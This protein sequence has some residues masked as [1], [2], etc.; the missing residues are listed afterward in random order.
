VPE[1]A[2]VVN[3]LFTCTANRVRSPFAAALA[4]QRVQARRLPVVVA[5]AGQLEPDRPAVD[6][7]V[8]VAQ[9]AAVDLTQ[10]RSTQLSA[11]LVEASD[12][13]VTMAGQ[14]VVDMVALTP[15]ARARTV[16]LRE[17]AAATESGRPLER[18]TPEAV[19]EW[20][21]LTTRRP[22]DLLLSGQLDV[23]DPIGRS[24]RHYRR[25][26]KEIE[27]LIEVCFAGDVGDGA[28]AR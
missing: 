9:A 26:A 8:E 5:S 17:W 19:A 22:L 7:M 27:A 14:H 12:L 28:T 3:V 10:H 15:A 2:D 4:R 20:A 16:T 11:A 21:A 1:A 13:I 6:D 24:R 18:W 25:A 23:D